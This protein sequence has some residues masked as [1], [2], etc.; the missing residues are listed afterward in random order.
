LFQQ[1]ALRS[2]PGKVFQSFNKLLFQS[3]QL[4]VK[5]VVRPVNNE[6]RGVG[7]RHGAVLVGLCS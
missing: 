7:C 1:R 5:Q 2:T 3:A 6:D 4:V